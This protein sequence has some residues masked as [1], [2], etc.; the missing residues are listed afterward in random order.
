MPGFLRVSTV[1]RARA[2]LDRF[3]RP[4]PRTSVLALEDVLGRVLAEDVISKMDV[5]PFD[6]AS[7]DGY[8]VRASNT[9]GADE[10]RPV[11]LTLVGRLRPGFWPKRRLRSGECVEISTGAPIPPG[12]DAVVMGEYASLEKGKVRICRAV[13]PGENVAER[14]S[15]LRRGRVA[16]QKGEVLTPVKAGLLAAVGVKRVRVFSPPR[17]AIISTGDEL[18]R[19]G[20]C[21]AKG[22]IYDVNGTT[23]SGAVRECGGT[24]VYLGI[25]RDRVSDIRKLIRKGLRRCDVLILSGGSSA[26]SGDVLPEIVNGM[27]SPGVIVHGLAL[28]PGK[29]T[30]IG[31][32][33]GKPVFGLP[34]YPVSAMMVFDQLVAD[35]IRALSGLPRPRR[36]N[37]RARLSTRV[38][39]ARGRK[40]LIP[41]KMSGKD[42]PTAEPILKGS[43]A[44]TSLS[45]ADGYIEVPIERELLEEG[46]LVEVKLFGG[47]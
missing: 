44:V 31:V 1:E 32:L 29:P 41:V 5:P 23:L 13:A 40:E 16:L 39:S 38:I 6:R 37:V 24:P 26:G 28:K 15:D 46:E 12:A 9:F 27:G 3:W 35:Y 36:L 30:F 43:G 47:A 20:G 2:T 22:K 8:A 34:G 25:A 4:S 10:G 7:F 18:A 17:I 33:G 19:P 45:M 14:G 21:L 42:G 11:E